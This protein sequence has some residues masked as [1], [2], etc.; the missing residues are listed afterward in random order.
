MSRSAAFYEPQPSQ[1]GSGQELA[2]EDRRAAAACWTEDSVATGS[3]SRASRNTPS[4]YAVSTLAVLD[5]RVACTPAAYA[6]LR[7]VSVTLHWGFGHIESLANPPTGGALTRASMVESTGGTPPGQSYLRI[8][9]RQAVRHV[10]A[11]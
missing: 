4:K 11:R 2:P 9:R 8:P 1:P 6:R 3:G 5:R 7:C 10:S